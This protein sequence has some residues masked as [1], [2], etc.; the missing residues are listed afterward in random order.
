M[1]RAGN[2]I[3]I[4]NLSTHL[5]PVFVVDS[6]HRLW[7]A[8]LSMQAPVAKEQQQFIASFLHTNALLP[9]R[10]CGPLFPKGCPSSWS[11]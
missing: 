6:H 3:H 7:R 8:M 10:E 9:H 5:L 4:S 11:E 1:C 2:A